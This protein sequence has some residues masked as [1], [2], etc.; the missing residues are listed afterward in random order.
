MVHLKKEKKRNADYGWPSQGVTYRS[1]KESA[2]TFFQ[3]FLNAIDKSNP[4]FDWTGDNFEV[5]KQ[6]MFIGV[7][8][9]EEYLNKDNEIK[10]GVKL[11]DIRSFEAKKEGLIK[12]YDT[13][14]KLSK[15]DR[16]KYEEALNKKP[17]AVGTNEII[18]VQSEDIPL[19]F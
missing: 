1:Y 11:Q 19:P 7:F 13:V 14:K 5:L 12:T 10:V 18:D 16:E 4:G 2:L 15:K 8:R 6:K 17:T 9:E 3:G